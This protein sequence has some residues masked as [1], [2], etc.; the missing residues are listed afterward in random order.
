MPCIETVRDT[1]R[2][3]QKNKASEYNSYSYEYLNVMSDVN[4]FMIM[5]CMRFDVFTVDFTVEPPRS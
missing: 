5:E 4:I 2:L 1:K 3:L